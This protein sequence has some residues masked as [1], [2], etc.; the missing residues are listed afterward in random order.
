MPLPGLFTSGKGDSSEEISPLRGFKGEFLTFCFSCFFFCFGPFVS[1]FD[2]TN[3]LKEKGLSLFPP[4]SAILDS[5]IISSGIFFRGLTLT[6]RAL[7][8]QFTPR[9][10]PRVTFSRVPFR[11]CKQGV[12]QSLGNRFPKARTWR[13]ISFRGSRHG[14]GKHMFI[15]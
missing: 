10:A 8:S 12:T 7:I 13:T 9:E 3:V 5:H 2:F 6:L 11:E 4:D 15:L 1:C 14:A